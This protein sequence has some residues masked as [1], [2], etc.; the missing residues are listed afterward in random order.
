MRISGLALLLSLVLPASLQAQR[1]RLNAPLERVAAGRVLDY[2]VS[3]DRSFLVYASDPLA[4]GVVRLA[5]ASLTAPGAVVD[6]GVALRTQAPFELASDGARV[7]YLASDAA[8]RWELDSVASDGSLAPVRLSPAEA[9]VSAFRI[10]T[11]GRRVVYLARLDGATS[12]ALFSVPIEGGATR[13]VSTA[14]ASSNVL[15]FVLAPDSE[16]VFFRQSSGSTID[17]F[18][19]SASGPSLARRL[20]TH[21][22]GR[23]VREY[24]VSAQGAEVVYR[25]DSLVDERYELFAVAA[26]GSTPRRLSQDFLTSLGDV[27]EFQLSPDG[28]R[29]VYLASAERAFLFELFSVSLQAGELPRRLDLPL[30]ATNSVTGFEL[31][32][33]GRRVAFLVHQRNP[34][35]ALLFSAPV[36]GSAAAARVDL[37][38]RPDLEP[39]TLHLAPDGEHVVYT[40][41]L[42]RRIYGARSDGATPP[43]LLATLSGAFNGFGADGERVVFGFT[44]LRVDGSEAPVTLDPSTSVGEQA[45]VVDDTLFY[46]LAE[47]VSSSGDVRRVDLERVPIDG[48]APPT[49]VS[50]PFPLGPVVDDVSTFALAGAANCAVYTT[51]S[52]EL[53]GVGTSLGARDV[54]L[55]DPSE[56]ELGG[57]FVTLDGHEVVFR[58]GSETLIAPLDGSR[59][60][61]A[62]ASSIEP[63]LLTPDGMRLVFQSVVG[64][65]FELG[66]VPLDRSTPAVTLARGI[67]STWLRVTPDSARVLFLGANGELSSVRSD[68]SAAAVGLGVQPRNG[69]PVLSPDGR[70]VVCTGWI[71]ASTDL[72]LLSVPVD[73]SSAPVVLEEPLDSLFHGFALD[74][75]S[76]FVV[77]SLWREAEGLDVLLRAPIAGGAPPL[78]LRES[79]RLTFGAPLLASDGSRALLADN[80]EYRPSEGPPGYEGGVRA[81]DFDVVAVALDGSRQAVPLNGGRVGPGLVAPDRH[82]VVQ[83]YLPLFPS[84]GGHVVFQEGVEIVSA[85]VDGSA[86]SVLATGATETVGV[87]AFTPD[88]RSAV[89]EQPVASGSALY[90]AALDGRRPTRLLSGIPASSGGIES[91]CGYSVRCLPAFQVA[92]DGSRVVYRGDLDA[93]GVYELYASSLVE[94]VLRAR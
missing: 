52:D 93:D 67:G 42:G 13:K 10:T 36:D 71:S 58:Q 74:A 54:L 50:A 8:G 5:R 44:S 31:D 45:R 1:I 79:P 81:F 11:D 62:L 65:E 48:R 29:V 77:Y 92:S 59:A 9:A 6:L 53:F 28:T 88:G 17:L 69:D 82:G 51:E 87:M 35:P 12:G 25:A 68:G 26:R 63:Q 38:D 78:V 16:S 27:S 84:P 18:R 94:N 37:D 49:Q 76:S 75:T 56:G 46:G 57:T 20:T 60:P 43:V 7:V 55:N 91:F 73:G 23:A 22:T 83:V 33:L 32:A 4:S 70:H 24:A 85:A 64:N 90:A 86:R 61:E 15:D 19:G 21:G 14:S 41:D 34:A 47:S 39:L 2:R 66:S 30:A 80:A 89:F 72:R 40:K 3:A